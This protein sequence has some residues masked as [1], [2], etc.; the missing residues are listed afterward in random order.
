MTWPATWLSEKLKDPELIHRDKYI[1][2]YK[3]HLEV[4]DRRSKK[5]FGPRFTIH[6]LYAINWN[7]STANYVNNKKY[8]CTK[9]EDAKL[10]RS[11]IN[12]L[13]ESRRELI[14][15]AVENIANRQELWPDIVGKGEMAF[16][17]HEWV[18]INY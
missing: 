13:D 9:H 5:P 11:G 2:N 15:K 3:D 4:R 12:I 17:R 6:G 7:K 10:F 18:I 16:Y 8:D 14:R 1:Q